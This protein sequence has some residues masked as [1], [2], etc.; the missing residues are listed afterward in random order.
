[1]SRP[2]IILDLSTPLNNHF[3]PSTSDNQNLLQIDAIEQ[4]NELIKTVH[5]QAPKPARN[6]EDNKSDEFNPRRCNNTIFIHGERG[7]GKTTFLRAVIN[8]YKSEGLQDQSEIIKI[9]PIPLIDPTLVQTHQHILVEII[10]KFVRLI[11]EKLNCCADE[12][13]YQQ[14][15]DKLEKMAEGLKLLNISDHGKAGHSDAAWFLDRALNKA[16]SGQDLERCF[17]QLL[18]TMSSILNTDLFLIA[19]DDVDTKTVKAYEVLEVL[20]CYLTQG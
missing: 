8:K 16:T 14:F 5:R 12:K 18:D 13:E 4:I 19:I 20:R 10:T 17:H 11:D 15:R 3:E 6:S 2:D 1:M 7:A 9:S